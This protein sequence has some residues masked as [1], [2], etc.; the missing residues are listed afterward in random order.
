MK[1]CLC[2]ILFFNATFLPGEM[3]LIT[4]FM[5]TEYTF[6]PYLLICFLGIC[7]TIN[8]YI[9]CKVGEEVDA[10]AEEQERIID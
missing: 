8:C 3:G 5:I 10:E 6:N 2:R 9:A 7:I 4:A 1:E